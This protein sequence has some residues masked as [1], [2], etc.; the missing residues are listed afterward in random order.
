L[1]IEKQINVNGVANAYPTIS[2]LSY[3]K[4]VN[5]MPSTWYLFTRLA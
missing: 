5:N 2:S 3:Q 1:Q 4:H